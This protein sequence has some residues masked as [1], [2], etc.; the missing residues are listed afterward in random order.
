MSGGHCRRLVA[1]LKFK[2]AAG[3]DLLPEARARLARLGWPTLRCKHLHRHHNEVSLL[4]AR[5]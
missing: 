1:T 5:G 3:Y 2:G 4:A